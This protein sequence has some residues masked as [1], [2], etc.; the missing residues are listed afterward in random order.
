LS[1]PRT[2]TKPFGHWT[3]VENQRQF[4]EEL[5]VKLNIT[6]L[7]DWNNVLLNTVEKEGGSFVRRIYGSLLQGSGDNGYSY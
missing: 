1:K 5:A 3:L 2:Q 4:F 6:K 7:D